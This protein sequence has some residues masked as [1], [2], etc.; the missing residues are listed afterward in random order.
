MWMSDGQGAWCNSCISALLM[1]K[2]WVQILM[3]AFL[4]I[5]HYKDQELLHQRLILT[6]FFYGMSMFVGFFSAK[7]NILRYFFRVTCGLNCLYLAWAYS[8]CSCLAFFIISSLLSVIPFNLSF[9]SL[10]IVL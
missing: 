8:N 5:I 9:S 6:T 1:L 3:C 2:V 7:K 10:L 4:N